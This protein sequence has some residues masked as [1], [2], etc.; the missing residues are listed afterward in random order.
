[1]HD[2]PLAYFIT[3]TVYGTFLQGDLRWWRS[4]GKGSQPAQPQLEQWHRSRLQHDVLL[5]DTDQRSAVEK[6]TARLCNFREWKLWS[7]N[8]RSNHV[9]VVVS[10]STQSG[11][12]VRDQIQ[13]HTSPASRLAFVPGS[14]RLDR[15]RR[16]AMYQ[17]RKRTGTGHRIYDRSTGSKSQRPPITIRKISR[18]AL[19]P[20]IVDL[21]NMIPKVKHFRPATNIGN[22]R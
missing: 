15:G 5:L 18:R 17:F 22:I 8:A 13:L 6:E 16:L 3:F 10:V 14:P 4:R 12:K 11:D 1:M 20:V 7:A 2:D 19:A 9:H 21:E